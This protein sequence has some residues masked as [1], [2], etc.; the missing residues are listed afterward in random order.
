MIGTPNALSGGQCIPIIKSG[1]TIKCAN[2]V[3]HAATAP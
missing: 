3:G 2:S 1:V